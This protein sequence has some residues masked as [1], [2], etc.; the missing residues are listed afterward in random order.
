MPKIKLSYSDWS[1]QVQYVTIMR[2]DNDVTDRTCVI[3]I[4]NEIELS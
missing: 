4:K 1:D 3:Y 2:Q